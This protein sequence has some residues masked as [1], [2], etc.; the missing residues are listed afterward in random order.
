MHHFL[1]HEEPSLLEVVFEQLQLLHRLSPV[2]LLARRESL[3]RSLGYSAIPSRPRPGEPA[4]SGR[5]L[6]LYSHR[7]VGTGCF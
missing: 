7:A 1:Y 5:F 4:I 2:S 6:L 3:T